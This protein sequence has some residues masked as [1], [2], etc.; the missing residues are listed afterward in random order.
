MAGIWTLQFTNP[1][2]AGFFD[3]IAF[4][5]AKRGLVVGDPVAGH[6]AIFVTDD[7]GERWRRVPS[8]AASRRRAPSPRA[9]RVSSSRAGGTRGSRPAARGSFTR[10]TAARRGLSRKRRSATTSASA[11]IF[12]IAMRDRGAE[13]QSA[14]ITTSPAT[15]S[16]TSRLRA[17]ADGPGRSPAS[18]RRV[19]GRPW[20]SC[21]R[22]GFGSPW[23][24]PDRT[25]RGMA[26][27]LEALRQGGL[28]RGRVPVG[29]RPQRCDREVRF[30]MGSSPQRR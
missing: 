18:G 10:P 28:Q 12:S 20:R 11:G 23:A 24:R 1:D 25:F 7:G 30:P 27:K 21:P 2:A 15:T 8:P 3:A 4:W 17:T 9:G 22:Y 16:T 29:G 14:A 6:F 26:A 19:T 5:D 13:S